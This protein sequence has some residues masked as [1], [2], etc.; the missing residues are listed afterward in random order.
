MASERSSSILHPADF[1]FGPLFD[2]ITDAVVVGDVH[3][4]RIVLWNAAAASIFGYRDD[5]AIG[6]P[7]ADLV[8]PELRAQHLRGLAQYA[9][10]GHGQLVDAG[11]V[12]DLP[13][14]RSDGR[15]IF[16]QL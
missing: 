9:K 2:A 13:A 4:G 10:S 12:V 14:L 11:D 5:E 1:G 3:T 16:V 6:R 8:V 7:L 15:R